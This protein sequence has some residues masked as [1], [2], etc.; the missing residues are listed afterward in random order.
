MTD[1]FDV[2][3]VGS[4]PNGLAAAITAAQAGLT[5][6]VIE[7]ADTLGGGLRSAEL[8]EPGFIHDVCSAIHP[9]LMGSPFLSSL[10]LNDHGLRML[11]PGVAFAHPLDG[12]RAA[13]MQ[14]SV[15]ATGRS[16]GADAASYA[17]LMNPL[18]K[19]ADALLSQFLA[20][21]R[22][23]ES[24]LAAA[25][26]G[27]NAVRS[28]QGVA[29]RFDG[30][31]ARALVAG[32][33]AHAGLPLHR[34]ATG[35]FALVLGFLAHSHGWPMAEGGSRNIAGALVS[36]LKSLGGSVITGWQVRDLAEL[37]PHKAVLLDVGPRQLITLAGGRLSG[38]YLRQ[39]QR[40]RYG[41][42]T[43]KVDWALDGPVPWT[44]E[45]LR[46]AGTIHLGG[47]LE[48]IAF[49]EL[50]I[51][52]GGVTERPYM[53]VAQQSLT[54]P[55]RAPEGKHTLWGYCH[56]P[57]GYDGDRTEAMENQIE[58]AAP[59]FKDLVLARHRMGPGRL[60][61]YNGNYV[62]GDINGGVQDIWQLFTRPVVKV[63]P[64]STP[65]PG[66]YLCSSSTPPGGGVHG[67][68]GH[69]AARSAL[70]QEF[71]LVP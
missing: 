21:P 56:V 39:L 51:W 48:E 34:L 71:G 11:H 10:P 15:E 53:I 61:D 23:P 55:S 28:A 7:A 46:Q 31:A 44:D 8:T 40:F 60:Q 26:F 16:L 62:G 67:M 68:C 17:A 19:S 18:V 37:P 58:Q 12:G 6:Q 4:G 3:V 63:N 47:T 70:K 27:V 30:P 69:F 49:S 33:A 14:R 65:I 57:T 2:V 35:G 45:R 43:F 38:G 25:R 20:P 5:V 50:Q 1:G 64:Y 42:G 36:Y 29:G 22:L 54:D 32:L 66:V 41:P 59:G 52:T 13:I 9:T 24:P